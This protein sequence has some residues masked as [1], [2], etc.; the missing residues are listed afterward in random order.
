MRT[1]ALAAAI[2][3]LAVIGVADARP[4]ADP[5]GRFTF[6]APQGWSVNQPQSNNASMTYVIAGNANNECQ[7]LAVANAQ[8]AS[9]PANAIRTQ[10]ANAFTNEMWTRALGSFAD[11]F[12]NGATPEISSTSVDT[13]GAWPIQRAEARAGERP[14]HGAIVVRPGVDVFVACL[15]YGGTEPIA[16][17]DQVIRSVG[18]PNDA[19]WAA[20]AETAPA[21]AAQ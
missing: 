5:A 3:A 9:A 2:A 12:R 11:I 13:S 17:Y 7:F 16:L 21:P 1:R 18:H 20:A 6:D 14:V 15:T 10:G 8:T 19:A 4:W